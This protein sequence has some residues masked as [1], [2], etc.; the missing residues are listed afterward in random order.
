MDRREFYSTGVSSEGLV[1]THPNSRITRN[2]EVN[3]PPRA[4]RIS[5]VEHM[6]QTQRVY[7]IAN[8]LNCLH[9]INFEADIVSRTGTVVDFVTVK[10]SA[11]NSFQHPEVF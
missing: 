9:S 1:E 3:R 8:Y 4:N 11:F 5:F 6:V 10:S 2:T 7:L